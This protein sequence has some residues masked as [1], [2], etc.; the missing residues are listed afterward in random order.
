MADLVRDGIVGENSAGSGIVLQENLR[1]SLTLHEA[2]L[3]T[4]RLTCISA[5]KPVIRVRRIQQL[6]DDDALRRLSRVR[7]QLHSEAS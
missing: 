3:D 6:V 2:D 4:R 1:L 7:K 5:V